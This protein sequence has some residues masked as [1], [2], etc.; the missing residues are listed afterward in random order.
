[1]V[2]LFARVRLQASALAFDV[3]LIGLVCVLCVTVYGWRSCRV[4]KWLIIDCVSPQANAA[5]PTALSLDCNQCA[6]SL[7]GDVELSD[8]PLTCIPACNSKRCCAS[9]CS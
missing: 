5:Q 3:W 8:P 2:A 9:F 4:F 6:Q 1:M 7:I